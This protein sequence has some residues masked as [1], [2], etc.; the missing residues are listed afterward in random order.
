MD[1]LLVFTFWEQFLVCLWYQIF[2]YVVLTSPTLSLTYIILSK[3][4]LV[5]VIFAT[6]KSLDNIQGY[7]GIDDLD[8]FIHVA[9]LYAMI[10]M[11]WLKISYEL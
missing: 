5:R 4:R 3:P 10:Y 1:G 9:C 6:H 2:L 11:L 7:T 8:D